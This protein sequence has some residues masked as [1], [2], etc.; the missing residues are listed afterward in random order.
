MDRTLLRMAEPGSF[1]IETSDAV[2]IA[3][4]ER[5]TPKEAQDIAHR[6]QEEISDLCSHVAA[7]INPEARDAIW[8]MRRSMSSRLAQLPAYPAQ[9]ANQ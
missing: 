5:N 8:A 7:A 2:V 6:A 3:E 1:P 9:L 4:F